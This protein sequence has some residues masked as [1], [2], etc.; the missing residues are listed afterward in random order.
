MKEEL[1]FIKMPNIFVWDYTNEDK[2]L[3]KTNELIPYIYTYLNCREDR[4]KQIIFSLDMLITGCGRVVKRGKGKSL[5][6]FKNTLEF[7]KEKE[8]I[9]Y[10]GSLEEIK[11]NTLIYAQDLK[12][13]NN[14][15]KHY[16][17]IERSNIITLLNLNTSIDKI[18][19]LNVYYYINARLNRREN[20]N[21]LQ[22]DIVRDGGRYEGFCDNLEVMSKHLNIS[23]PTLNECLKLLK[24]NKLICYGNIGKITNGEIVKESSNIYCIQESEYKEGIKQQKLYY[25]NQGWIPS[26]NG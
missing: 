5:E 7:F 21:G 3:I 11:Y 8:W 14:L 2:S 1:G 20:N 15:Q 12:N 16:F 26:I 6:T 9:Y 13:Y 18:K 17:K 22:P 23:K 25:E 10:V 4:I 24:D 19:I